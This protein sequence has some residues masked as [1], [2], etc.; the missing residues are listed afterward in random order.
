MSG[1]TPADT[2]GVPW[3]GRELPRQPFAADDGAADPALTRAVAGYVAGTVPMAEVVHALAAARVLVPVVAVLGEDHPL[4]THAR[5]DLGADM[6][7]VTVTG[8]DGRTALPVFSSL[9]TLARWNPGARPVPVESARAALAAVAEDC[10]LL[11]LDAAG[12]ATVQVPRPAMWALGQGRAWMPPGDD[13]ELAGA[14]DQAVRPVPDVLATRCEPIGD[15]GVRIVLG[16]RAGL[17]QSDLAPVVHAARALIAEV[18]LL[19]ERADA[20]Q[21]TVL[22]A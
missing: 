13:P 17:S 16:V 11:V 1:D 8:P 19:A 6:A 20:V 3:A 7:I 14:V 12:P 9:E 10:D 22:P 4:P 15:T 5:G 21:L 2:A 18:E